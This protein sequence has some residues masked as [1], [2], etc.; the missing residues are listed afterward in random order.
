MSSYVRRIQEMLEAMPNPADQVAV[1]V[2]AMEEA[3]KGQSVDAV[4]TDPGAGV[5]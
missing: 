5:R 1:I 3:G 4:A 2:E